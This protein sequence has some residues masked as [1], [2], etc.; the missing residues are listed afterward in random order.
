MLRNDRGI[1]GLSKFKD[2]ISS[3]NC[4]PPPEVLGGVVEEIG[5]EKG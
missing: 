4:H 3:G 1:S 5:E 2:R